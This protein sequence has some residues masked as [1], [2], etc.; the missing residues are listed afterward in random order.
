MSSYSRV[1][2]LAGAVMCASV[3]AAPAPFAHAD[4]ARPLPSGIY[5]HTTCERPDHVWAIAAGL[6][7]VIFED[8]YSIYE[9]IVGDREITHDWRFYGDFDEFGYTFVRMSPEGAIEWISWSSESEEAV[10]DNEWIDV[11]PENVEDIEDGWN[12][13]IYEPCDTFPAAFS[14]IHVE[15]I[16]FLLDLDPAAESCMAAEADCLSNVFSV[17]DKYRDNQLTIAELSRTFRAAAYIGVAAGSEFSS[18]ETDEAVAAMAAVMAAAPLMANLILSNYDY[19][20]NDLLSFD[21]FRNDALGEELFARDSSEGRGI[22][23]LLMQVF[24]DNKSNLQQWLDALLKLTRLFG[25]G[26]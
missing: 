3:A 5:G 2:L 15:P 18:A 13:A 16:G 8:D 9:H 12:I 25:E 26:R 21:E 1:S 14:P 19:D 6:D 24:A 20:G 4:G 10:D 23:A 11:L 22:G 7:L 17:I